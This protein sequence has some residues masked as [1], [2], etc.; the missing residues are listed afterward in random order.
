MR[1]R[2]ATRWSKTSKIKRY[3][4]SIIIFAAIFVL[5]LLLHPLLGKYMP[6]QLFFYAGCVTAFFWGGGAGAVIVALGTVVGSYFFV[7][8]YLQ[9]TMPNGRDVVLLFNYL[10]SCFLVIVTI[11]YLQRA[12]Y[13][14]E[15]LLRVSESRYKTLL[16]R[17][18]QRMLLERQA[19]LTNNL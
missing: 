7:E 13:K 12:R 3:L 14:S 9:F 6:Y 19:R 5:R 17:D 2:N 1:V 15:L 18:N 8:P 4:F 11:E 10:V 16:H